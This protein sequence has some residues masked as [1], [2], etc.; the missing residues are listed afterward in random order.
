MTFLILALKGFLIGIAFIVPGVSGGTVAIYLGL[1]DEMIHAIGSI[2]TE[3][4]KSVRLLIPILLGVGV[5]VVSLAALLGWLFNLNSFITLMLFI[6]LILGGIP[7]L[8]KKVKKQPLSISVVI[9]FG[10]A[11]LLVMVLLI[12]EKATASAG[13]EYFD[14]KWTN[15]LLIFGLGMISSMTMIVPGISGSALLLAL[16]FYTAIVSNVIGNILD[17]SQ[18]GYHL[19]VVIPFALGIAVGIILFSK[20]IEFLLRKFSSQTYGAIIGFVFASVI[21]IFLEIRDPA[22]A[23]EFMQQTPIYKQFFTYV[24]SNWLSI[25]IGIMMAIAGFLFAFHFVLPEKKASDQ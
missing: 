5:S 19:F 22:T 24:T 6:G 20:V 18:I 15:F 1:Y 12:A 9:S 25:V 8:W 4:K 7:S 21:V 11:F 3:F 23:S 13:F 10:I 16:G 17:F 14:Q 2:F